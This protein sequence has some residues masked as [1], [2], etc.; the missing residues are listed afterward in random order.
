M[1]LYKNT[2]DKSSIYIITTQLCSNMDK[3]NEKTATIACTKNADKNSACRLKRL[4]HLIGKKWTVEILHKTGQKPMTYN[5]L[6]SSLRNEVNP[7]LLSDRL[8]ELRQY[9]ILKREV[10]DGRNGYIITKRGAELKEL[11]DLI[12]KWSSNSVCERRRSCRKDEC[13]CREIV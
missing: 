12:R 11:L 7:T 13:I 4:H 8:K 2:K 3:L 9:N 10:R 1:T 5:E 6:K